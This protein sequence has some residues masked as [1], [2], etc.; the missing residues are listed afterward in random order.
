MRNRDRAVTSKPGTAMKRLLLAMLAVATVG[1]HAYRPITTA[2]PDEGLDVALQL[3]DR[4]GEALR[5]SVG[6]DVVRIEGRVDSRMDSLVVL[7]VSHTQTASGIRSRWAGERIGVRP[8]WVRY[9]EQRQFSRQRTALLV[10]AAVAA[11]VTAGVMSDGFG[12][13]GSG[14]NK[15]PPDPDPGERRMPRPL[16]RTQDWPRGWQHEAAK[17]SSCTLRRTQPSELGC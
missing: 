2:T 6:P 3:N 16:N 13:G 8:E 11:V 1:C 7:S 15:V 17:P 12:F 9:A 14:D 10:G 4:G 5:D